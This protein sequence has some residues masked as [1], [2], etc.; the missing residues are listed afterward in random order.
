M[1][2]LYIYIILFSSCSLYNT[3]VNKQDNP[4]ILKFNEVIDFKNINK[5]DITLA[6]KFYLK[7]A[8]RILNDIIIIPQNNY[9]QH[10]DYAMPP[11]YP[12]NIPDYNRTYENTLLRMDDFYKK[13]HTVWNII[14]LL[15]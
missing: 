13:V 8:D 2:F 11:I 10:P 1:Y 9:K 7:Q 3:N 4:L 15:S 5:G 14:G 6:T 12:D